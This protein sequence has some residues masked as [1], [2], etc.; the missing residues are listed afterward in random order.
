MSKVTI[1]IPAYNQ[2]RIIGTAILSALSQDYQDKEVLVIDDHSTDST[3]LV[4][5]RHKVRLIRNEVNLGISGNLKKCMEYA[6]GEYIIY[7]CGD[8]F[9]TCNQV[10]G[11]MVKIFDENPKVGVIG[12]R[13]YQFMD[14]YAGAI[15]VVKGDIIVTSS[16][17]SGIGFRRSAMWGEFSKRIFIE[18]PHMVEKVITNWDYHM[19][20]YDTIAARIHPGGNTGT[21]TSYYNDSPT[22]VLNILKP[23][24][25]FYEGFINLKCRA[26]HVLLKDIFTT[27]KVK[28]SSLLDFKF[29]M[30][31]IIALV[32]PG[33]VLRPL[34]NF[35]RH[36]I[37]R[38]F[39]DIELRGRA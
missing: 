7:L 35:Y 24:Y 28:P 8:D 14:G 25:V 27:I 17:P 2:Q 30:Y 20:D 9:F 31:A 12:R 36:R 10:V 21:L 23:G 6:E 11:D 26:S 13:Y 3:F 4:C 34:A 22:K 39:Y 16:N 5:N 38:R 37:K 1:A 32:V 15:N 33:R 29:W 18:V 19:M